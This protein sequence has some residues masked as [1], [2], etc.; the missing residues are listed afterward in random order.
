VETNTK[1]V[2]P[3]LVANEQQTDGKKVGFETFKLKLGLTSSTGSE[4]AYITS[5]AIILFIT[6]V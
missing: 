4:G 2:S 3:F 6:F 5:T 1:H